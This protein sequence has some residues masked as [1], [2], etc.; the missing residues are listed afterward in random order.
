MKEN[1]SKIFKRGLFALAPLAI[2]VAIIVW[3]LSALERVFRPPLEFALGKYY[4]PGLGIIFA[5][6]V[7]LFVGGIINT[8]L[9]QKFTKWFHKR[10]RRIPFFKTFYNS[11]GDLMSYFHPKTEEQRGRMVIV[12]IAEMRF[13]A[14][15]TC[16]DFEGMPPGLGDNDYVAVMIPFSY[17]I[18]GFTITVPRSKIKPINLSVEQGMR[19]ILT[20]GVQ[21]KKGADQ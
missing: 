5:L 1:L 20:A 9:I 16:E 3:L 18:G 12:E 13:L 21:Q 19:F 6:I 15:L 2:S 8:Y 4:F 7:I 11:V 10:L 17:Q 14:L